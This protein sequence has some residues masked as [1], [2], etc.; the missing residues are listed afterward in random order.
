MTVILTSVRSS[1][2]VSF[3]SH[4]MSTVYIMALIR[5]VQAVGRV[6]LNA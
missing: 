5:R 2:C 3:V 1:Q 4:E 6:G